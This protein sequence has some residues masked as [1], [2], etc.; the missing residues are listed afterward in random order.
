M[1]YKKNDFALGLHMTSSNVAPT[2]A[3]TQELPVAKQK[4]MINSAKLQTLKKDKGKI[5]RLEVMNNDQHDTIKS[6]NQKKRKHSSPD[7]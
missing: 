6:Q 1:A 3:P 4:S 2:A 5:N 7:H